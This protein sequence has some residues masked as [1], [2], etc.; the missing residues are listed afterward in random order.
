MAFAL[1][2]SSRARADADEEEKP[3]TSHAA[4]L[5]RD[6]AGHVFIAIRPAAQKEIGISTETLSATVRPLEIEAY[7]YILDPSPL[8][9]L[10]SG[11]LTARAALDAAGAQYRRTSRLY[12][13]QKNASL[14]DLQTAQALYLTDESQLEALEQQLRNTWGEEV[15][16][17]DPQ[18]R[19]Q[20][21]SALVRRREAVARVTAPIG[22]ESVED[23][24]SAQII[25][26]GH[27]DQPLTTHAIF[28]AP[29][30]VPALQ[31]QSFLA[32]V[33]TAGFP[34]MPG[35]A[36]S[37]RI[38]ASN[39]LLRGVVVPRSAVVRYASA[40]WVYR[41]L[42]GDRFVRLEI[43][44]A[45]ITGRGYFVT[46]GLAPGMKIVIS[47]AQTLLSEELKSQIQVQD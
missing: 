26:L 41:E 44:P 32:L 28:A 13:E 19:S 1:G 3:I 8:S 33:T 4:Q 22:G 30:I 16:Q 35:M 9:K 6:A 15:A 24:R 37:A 31:G 43:A 20:L 38:P 27:E 34:V 36:A 17:M 40:E 2:R 10:N 45:E 12:A 42:D 7:G 23:P 25:V 5:S 18:A 29:T 21:V 11:L 47:G 39:R 14:R 46:D